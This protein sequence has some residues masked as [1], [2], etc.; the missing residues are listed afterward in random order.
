MLPALPGPLPKVALYATTS[1]EE[2][3]PLRLAVAEGGVP[4]A[5]LLPA[6]LVVPVDVVPPVPVPLACCDVVEPDV[7][8][9]A[10]GAGIAAA[11]RLAAA[12]I[13]AACLL[14]RVVSRF[15]TAFPLCCAAAT[16]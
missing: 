3:N 13:A 14:A 7:P 2:G 1:H 8:L 5:E 12:M 4:E 9:E 16:I 10:V 15:T 6:A 11:C